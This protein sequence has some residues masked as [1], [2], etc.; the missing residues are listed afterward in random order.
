MQLKHM[1]YWEAIRDIAPEDL[2]S[3]DEMGVLLEIMREQ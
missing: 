3:L 1:E 2:V